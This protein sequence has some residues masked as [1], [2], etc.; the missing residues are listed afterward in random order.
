MPTVAEL[1]RLD[2][3]VKRLVPLTSMQ[4]GELIQAQHWNLV[5]G[6]LV[7]LA[8]D[9][10]AQ[11]REGAVPAHG[12]P[13]Q[14]SAG[15]LDP[16]LRTL[17]ERGPLADPS[18]VARVAELERRLERVLGEANQL[19]SGLKDARDRIADVSTRDLARQADITAIRR[20]IEGMSDARDDVRAVRET[21]GQ[22]QSDVRVA[23]E[24]GARL[25]VDGQPVDMQAFHTRLQDVEALR[26]RLRLPT[27]ALLDAQSLEIRFTEL[28]NQF[29]TEE[30]LDAAFESRLS[31][32]LNDLRGQVLSAVDSRVSD[33]TGSLRAEVLSEVGA[34]LDGLRAEFNACVADIQTAV[35]AQLAQGLT[36]LRDQLISDLDGR[37]NAATAAL[38]DELIGQFQQTTESLRAEIAAQLSVTR[39]DFDA[40]LARRVAEL[41]SE[42]AQQIESS[43]TTN[44][45]EL[46]RRL[47]VALARLREEINARSTEFEKAIDTQLARGL[48]EIRREIGAQLD[49]R[50]GAMMEET[51]VMVN[52]AVAPHR[53]MIEELRAITA[54]LDERV[55]LLERRLFR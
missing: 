55:T 32:E 2:A 28:V 35:N 30:E 40:L 19:D 45:D 38:R 18:N 41:Q 47:E 31:G 10:L 53:R 54:R 48:A 11:E 9:V 12:H 29:I 27:G 51:K 4:R 24:V 5:V 14:V 42:V 36:A 20:I 17:V 49:Q 43:A 21:L 46:N 13:D 33:A 25:L 3:L 34:S 15:W 6:A 7:E 8:R 39:Q 16:R 52:E 26:E 22:L 23:V 44:R 50:L 37:D 1:E